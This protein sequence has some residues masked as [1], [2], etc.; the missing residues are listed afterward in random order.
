MF[1]CANPTCG[2]PR[3]S[4]CDGRLFQFEIVAISVAANDDTSEPFDEKPERKITHC[5]LCDS[6]ASKM[7]VTL[8]PMQGLRVVPREEERE[9]GVIAQTR[10]GNKLQPRN[11][12]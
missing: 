3:T 2:V 5:W 6:C 12:C 10:H 11:P 8:D 1:R 7:S 9:G 4:F